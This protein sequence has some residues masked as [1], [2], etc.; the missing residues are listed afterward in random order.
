MWGSNI[1]LC[2]K[3]TAREKILHVDHVCNYEQGQH[4]YQKF[5]DPAMFFVWRM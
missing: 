1:R 2:I 4:A 3:I 5:D